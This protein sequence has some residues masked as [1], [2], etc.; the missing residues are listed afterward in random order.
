MAGP[1]S[2]V[3][4]ADRGWAKIIVGMPQ[5]LPSDFHSSQSDPSTS[6]T[7]L[8]SIETAAVRGKHGEDENRKAA[9]E[10]ASHTDEPRDRT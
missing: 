1:A 6:A 5:Q 9:V 4:S 7:V 10:V 3:P 8:G 2:S